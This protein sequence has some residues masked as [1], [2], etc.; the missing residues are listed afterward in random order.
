MTSNPSIEPDLAAFELQA[1]YCRAMGHPARL[2]ILHYLYQAGED[3]PSAFLLEKLK[4]TKAGLSQHL[5]KMSM[6][7]LIKTRREGR[8]LYVG[9]ACSEVGQACALVR[10]ALSKDAD[11][12]VSALT[13]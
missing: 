11:S 1:E 4:I 10:S 13:N 7:G 5:A 6:V 8:F 12:R 3:I 2:M 9:L